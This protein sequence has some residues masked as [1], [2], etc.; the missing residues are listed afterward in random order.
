MFSDNY[1]LSE[2]YNLNTGEYVS[3]TEGMPWRYTSLYDS[4]YLP[5][6]SDE[7]AEKFN[8]FFRYRYLHAK[9]PHYSHNKFLHIEHVDGNIISYEL[10]SP[11]RY[12]TVK[13]SI[14]TWKHYTS[15]IMCEDLDL[16]KSR[17][18]RMTDI[19]DEMITRINKISYDSDLSFSSV[20]I[21][22]D[23]YNLAGYSDNI[24][25]VKLNDFC[26]SG[27][28]SKVR[29]TTKI[30]RDENSLSFKVLF[31]F[32]V[33]VE[34]PAFSKSTGERINDVKITT[35]VNKTPERRELCIEKLLEYGLITDENAEIIRNLCVGNSKFSLEYFIDQDGNYTSVFIDVVKISEFKD[36]TTA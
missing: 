11:S 9:E 10:T 2:R 13:Q 1:F 6:L 34:R 23:M 27:S 4:R 15:S 8:A 20:T 17:I 36:L 12:S 31:N 26:T 33:T 5:V 18:D 21:Y 32:P 30:Y 16:C 28:N 7:A 25:L 22:D 3:T 14:H 29:G 24:G 35:V 19:T